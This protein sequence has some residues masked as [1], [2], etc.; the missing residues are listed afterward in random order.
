MASR[1]I[2]TFNKGSLLTK[3]MLEEMEQFPKVMLELTYTDYSDG[4]ISGIK[5]ANNALGQSVLSKG[6][7]KHNGKYYFL[8]E[9]ILLTPYLETLI[10]EKEYVLIL[11]DQEKV[12]LCEGIEEES[13]TLSVS[14]REEVSSNDFVLGSFLHTSSRHLVLADELEQVNHLSYFDVSEVKYA[15]KKQAT[16]VPEYFE[17][18]KKKLMT[19]TGQH[20]MDM[21]LLNAIFEKEVVSYEWLGYYIETVI[22]KKPDMTDRKDVMRKL[23]EAVYKPYEVTTINAP[24]EKVVSGNVRKVK[25]GLI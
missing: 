11:K 24:Q 1:K 16:F 23:I 12:T 19:K 9:D 7:L 8:T 4:I 25:P 18:I 20:P 5:I 22:G 15:F 3:A 13:L 2:I 17:L 21:I 6:I 10:M 14:T